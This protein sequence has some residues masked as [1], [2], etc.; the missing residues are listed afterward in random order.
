M[1]AQFGMLF[2]ANRDT[3]EKELILFQDLLVHLAEALLIIKRQGE[4]AATRINSFLLAPAFYVELFKSFV[5]NAVNCDNL[6]QQVPEV[7]IV[8]SGFNVT[9]LKVG[10]G[11]RDNGSV[12]FQRD[13]VKVLQSQAHLARSADDFVFCASCCDEDTSWDIYATGLPFFRSMYSSMPQTVMRSPRCSVSWN[14]VD[15]E[16]PKF[17]MGY[18][19]V[20]SEKTAAPLKTTALVFFEVDAVLYPVHAVLM[21]CSASY[22]R[23][24]IKN[25]Q[26]V[27]GSCQ[28]G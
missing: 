21:I 16:G 20:F 1:S 15:A 25:G 23:W 11:L 6:C 7:K 14:H 4:V 10:E 22:R 24:L 18:S 2:S 12:L 3:N 9:L 26:S 13:L 5:K 17:L 19:Q 27:V 8:N 28:S